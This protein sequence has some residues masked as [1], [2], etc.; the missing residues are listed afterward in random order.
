MILVLKG[1]F[2]RYF[3]WLNRFLISKP[4]KTIAHTYSRPW[5]CHKP[6]IF[7]YG[8]AHKGGKTDAKEQAFLFLISVT[9]IP[10]QQH[11]G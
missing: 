11:A 7:R 8:Y 4:L 9:D 10:K 5:D 6:G 1:V 2:D 3:D